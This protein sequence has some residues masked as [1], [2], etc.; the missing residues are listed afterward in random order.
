MINDIKKLWLLYQTIDNFL[1]GSEILNNKNCLL[2]PLMSSSCLESSEDPIPDGKE[3]AII[4]VQA[5]PISSVV[6]LMVGGGI[7]DQPQ[8]PEV[9]HQLRMNPELEEKYEL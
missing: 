2:S 9:S 4:L 6:N 5:I 3:A 8:G 1:V 7:E